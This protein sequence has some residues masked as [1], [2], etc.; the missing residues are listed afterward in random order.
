MP[1]GSK[2]MNNVLFTSKTCEWSTPQELFDK[3]NKEFEFTLDPCADDDNHK[4]DKYYTRQQNG[5][6]QSWGKERVFC[7]PPYGRSIVDWVQK[8]FY[9]DGLLCIVL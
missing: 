6:L 4:C 5:L 2:E 3:L 1:G 8:C 7:N 9:E